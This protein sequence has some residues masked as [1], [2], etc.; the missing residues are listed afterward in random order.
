MGNSLVRLI[1]LA[2]AFFVP[3]GISVLLWNKLLHHD[4]TPDRRDLLV[5][6]LV[7]FLLV[8]LLDVYVLT[9]RTGIVE[10]VLSSSFRDAAFAAGWLLQSS[11]LAVALPVAGRLLEPLWNRNKSKTGD[12]Y[13]WLL[14]LLAVVLFLLNFIN[15]FNNNFWG[16]EAYTIRL[17]KMT[18][19]D[20]LAATAGDVHPPFFYFVEMGLYRLFGSHG[21]VFRLASIIPYGLELVFVL[22]VVRK[23]FGDLPAMLMVLFSSVLQ[24]SVMYNV[25]ARMYA[26]A[27]LFVL[28]AYDAFYCLL[29]EPDQLRYWVWFVLASLGAAYTHYYALMMVAFFYLALIIDAA[30]KR[31]PWRKV[32]GVCLMTVAG[33]LPWLVTMLATFFRTS[34]SFWMTEIP[35]FVQGLVYFFKARSDLYSFSMTFAAFVVILGVLLWG[36]N[37]KDAEPVQNEPSS[38]VEREWFIWGLV[39]SLGIIGIGELISHLIRPAYIVRYSYPASP[40]IWLLFGVSLSKLNSGRS[41]CAAVAV[42]TLLVCVPQMVNTYEKRRQADELCASTAEYVRNTI[43]ENDL[44]VTDVR[45]L[46]WTILDYY[47]PGV[48]H[49]Y[50][51]HVPEETDLSGYAGYW[52]IWGS[53]L[54]EDDTEVLKEEGYDATEMFHNGN[55]GTLGVHIYQLIPE[56]E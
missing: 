44:M 28:L 47:V 33:Y 48:D 55:L 27:S 15:I 19:G 18:A 51:D 7:F 16:D 50:V 56:N 12:R 52:L 39:M 36:W 41:L 38:S 45:H 49:V 40:V 54:S 17:A 8:H 34:K 5:E 6:Y 31:L 26:W 30:R 2:A 35:S 1:L 32:L 20:M 29:R 23:Q 24:S 4:R 25:E 43:G 37:G 21:W 10:T 46:D 13:G 42:S 14:Y 11:L 9:W 53:D 22:R 3:A